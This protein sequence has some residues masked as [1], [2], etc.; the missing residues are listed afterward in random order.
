MKVVITGTSNGIGLATAQLFIDRGH[1]VIGI[2][3]ESCHKLL[4]SAVKDGTYEHY[5]GDVRKGFDLPIIQ[6]ADILINNA[7]SQTPEFDNDVDDIDVNL[8]GLINCTE[9]YALNNPKIKSVVKLAS[10]SAHNGAEFPRYV[11]SKGGV[12][13]YTVW[14]AKA[15]A[16]F[17]ATCN[18][19]SFGGVLTNLNSPVINDKKKWD[20]IM[21]MTPLKKWATS[22][23]CAEWIY[24]ISV[25]NKSMSGQDIIIDNLE[26][27]NHTFVWD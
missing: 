20:H 10:V 11:A 23:E 14:T 13:A 26:M 21:S 24:F 8:K 18:S 12:I 9:R 6:E 3:I 1:H 4:L 2:D 22:E 16:K 17:G 25:V 19:L 5:K 27:L 7:G 15:L